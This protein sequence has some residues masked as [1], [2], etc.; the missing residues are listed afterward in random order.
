VIHFLFI[1]ADSIYR[2]IPTVKAIVEKT[3]RN[4]IAIQ[5]SLKIILRLIFIGAYHSVLWLPRQG[6]RT[7]LTFGYPDY[8]LCSSQ[9]Q[10]FRSN[11]EEPMPKI[12]IIA[13]PPGQAP[14][15]IRKSWVGLEME[16]LGQVPADAVLCGAVDGRPSEVN[17]N[18]FRV[19]A[20]EALRVLEAAAPKAARW[21]QERSVLRDGSAAE[22]VFKKDVCLLL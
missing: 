22:L 10:P 12:R 13:T 19:T 15:E 9:R 17:N 7:A 6:M 21:W 11:K 4:A 3:V 8:N 5:T 20:S 16:T 18:G 14:E 2:P 1:A